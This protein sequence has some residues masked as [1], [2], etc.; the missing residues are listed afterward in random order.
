MLAKPLAP[1]S[2][3]LISCRNSTSSSL[4]CV[5]IL[6]RRQESTRAEE[7]EKV[8]DR[9]YPE[10]LTSDMLELLGCTAL[11]PLWKRAGTPMCSPAMPRSPFSW[12]LSDR[13]GR[14][15]PAPGA[16]SQDRSGLPVPRMLATRKV[17]RLSIGTDSLNS[18]LPA[19]SRL[20][21]THSHSVSFRRPPPAADLPASLGRPS[22]ICR[23]LPTTLMAC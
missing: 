18:S 16:L 20:A 19:G 1:L 17:G 11:L 2:G 7:P 12:L 10:S 4:S 15:Q 5:F 3:Y 13:A 21:R 23:I 9:S 22:W 8:R 14:R 6:S